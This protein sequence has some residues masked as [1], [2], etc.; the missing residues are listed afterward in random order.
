MEDIQL[1][2]VCDHRVLDEIL[3]LNGITPNYFSELKFKCSLDRGSIIIREFNA[4]EN[5]IDFEPAIDGITD[6]N[7]D[8]T[9]KQ[10]IQFNTLFYTPGVNFVD[11]TTTLIPLRQYLATYVVN[12]E[13]D[14]PKC[15]GTKKQ[16]D[17]N[18]DE[19]GSLK[20]VS[21]VERVKQIIIKAVLTNRGTNVFDGDYGSSLNQSIGQQAL[22][23]AILRIQQSVQDCINRL[24]DS[25]S[26][27]S[28]ITPDD[29]IILGLD[30]LQVVFDTTDPRK[31]NI[32][33][34]IVIGTYEKIT[35]NLENIDI[36]V[37]S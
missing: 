30:D 1:G 11:G 23:I 24:I 31:V 20:V 21:G 3:T 36:G 7:I 9:G 6:Y 17:I 28:D 12:S 37:S 4:T 35:V 22:P 14:C 15:L 33:M 13:D 8:P 16:N 34:V 10:L 27:N 19:L 5:K 32:T 29:E 18:Y 26:Q 2:T 25:Q